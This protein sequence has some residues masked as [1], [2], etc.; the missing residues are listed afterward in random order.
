M[1]RTAAQD[2]DGLHNLPLY[3]MQSTLALGHRATL[4]VDGHNVLFTLPALFRPF[5]ENGIPGGRAREALEQR[6][7]ALARRH[8]R[9]S[10]QLWFDGGSVSERTVQ[11]NFRVHF[12][13]G[14][15]S[16]RADRQIL[17]FLHHLK[18][19]SP[20]LA[21]TVVT[22]DQDEAR[23]ADRTGAMVMAPEELALWLGE[24]RPT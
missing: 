20:D 14:S 17:A 13:G 19:S 9:L 8:P 6:L 16:N 21:R 7:A 3:A 24:Q 23:S 4:V 11:D 22:A 15:G 10:I 5:F 1:C 18:S 12:S 2:R